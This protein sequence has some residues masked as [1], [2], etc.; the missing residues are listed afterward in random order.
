MRERSALHILLCSGPWWRSIGKY[1]PLL[2]FHFY[3]HW[4][5]RRCRRACIGMRWAAIGIFKRR[6]SRVSL[7]DFVWAKFSVVEFA[8]GRRRRAILFRFDVHLEHGRHIW[9]RMVN[10]I[11]LMVQVRNRRTGAA[12]TTWQTGDSSFGANAKTPSSVTLWWQWA[13]GR[14]LSGW[15]V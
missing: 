7:L 1:P 12:G 3:W 9:G 4:G 11:K 13:P 5:T 2:N 15:V 14:V 10:W 8:F 6:W